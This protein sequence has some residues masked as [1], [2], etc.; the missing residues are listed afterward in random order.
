MNLDNYKNFKVPHFFRDLLTLI[1]GIVFLIYTISYFNYNFFLFPNI[2][3]IKDN[4]LLFFLLVIAVSYFAG[5]VLG[6][7]ARVWFIV[8]NF[9]LGMFTKPRRDKIFKYY[10][11][12]FKY[13]FSEHEL[14]RIGR[15]EALSR[16]DVLIY[17]DKSRALQDEYFRRTY[18]RM[19]ADLILGGCLIA[20]GFSLNYYL[21]AVVVF[22]SFY[23][24]EESFSEYLHDLRILE[25]RDRIVEHG[26]RK[27]S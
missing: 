6:I 16:E 27:N 13:H 17:L 1:V 21:V 20:C 18:Y 2:L 25:R 10:K 11:S 7:I 12:I 19:F 8:I 3:L 26:D 23:H 4:S 5:R 24:Y 15:T 22:L 14:D 9:C